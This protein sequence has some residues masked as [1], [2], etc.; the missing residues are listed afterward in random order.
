VGTK[1]YEETVNIAFRAIRKGGTMCLIGVG[2]QNRSDLPI[3]PYHL[4]HY[5]KRIFGVL[6]GDAQFKADIPR[7][8]DLYE[9]GKIDLDGMVT[10]EYALE[11]INT[12]FQ[13][14]LAEN[15]VARQVIRF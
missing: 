2:P 14:V 4:M 10:K 8:I 1:A 6:F 12:A 5:R 11:D 15:K 13:N 7:Y 9:Q 3:D